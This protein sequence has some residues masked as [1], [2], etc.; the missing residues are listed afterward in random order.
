MTLLSDLIAASETGTILVGK[1]SCTARALSGADSTRL[2]CAI[3]RPTPPLGPDPSKG[4]LAPW[5]P[6][7]LDPEY[8][9][10]VEA[11]WTLFRCA[12]VAA[13]I[14]LDVSP[15]GTWSGQRDDGQRKA[16]AAAAADAIAERLTLEQIAAAYEAVM[17]LGTDLGGVLGNS[18]RGT[19]TG[20]SPTS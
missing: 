15:L 1:R 2:R 8:N 19:A 4:S 3:A 11:W 5:V 7:E 18:E 13:A 20:P 17:K 14:D 10:R 6:N 12:T 9:A 16:W